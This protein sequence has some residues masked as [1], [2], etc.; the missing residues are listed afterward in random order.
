[1]SVEGYSQSELL[2]LQ[3]YAL[4]EA[5]IRTFYKSPF[6]I[7]NE[8][9][10]AIEQKGIGYVFPANE[11]SQA[12]LARVGNLVNNASEYD[13]RAQLEWKNFNSVFPQLLDPQ[14]QPA[15]L[16]G[17]VIDIVNNHSKRLRFPKRKV[18]DLADDVLYTS[19]PSELVALDSEKIEGYVYPKGIIFDNTL[20][21]VLDCASFELVGEVVQILF[22]QDWGAKQTDVNKFLVDKL[23]SRMK[24]VNNFALANGQKTSDMDRF[25]AEAEVVIMTLL[26]SEGD[27]RLDRSDLLV[28]I[29][30]ASRAFCPETRK[31]ILARVSN[32]SFNMGPDRSLVIRSLLL[33]IGKRDAYHTQD[34]QLEQDVRENIA[35]V[36]RLTSLDYDRG[37]TQSQDY[38]DLIRTIM[39]VSLT[40]SRYLPTTALEILKMVMAMEGVSQEDM[41]LNKQYQQLIISKNGD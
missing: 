9:S 33:S 2:R 41:K 10:K 25:E 1:M 27:E 39:N 35:T 12:L 7:F 31:R 20:H 22:T 11:D 14:E 37:D 26:A 18:D 3:G 32:D 8:I 17:V 16:A 36:M 13:P 40:I 30:E 4:Q 23:A 21:R 34:I 6:T 15:S 38:K 29:V 24:M 19:P 28:G 5:Y